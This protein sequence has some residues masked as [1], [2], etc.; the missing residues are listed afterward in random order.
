MIQRCP[1][2]NSSNTEISIKGYS[3][4]RKAGFNYLRGVKSLA[5][6]NFNCLSSGF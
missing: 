1:I 6:S 2:C 5:S 3:S 4:R